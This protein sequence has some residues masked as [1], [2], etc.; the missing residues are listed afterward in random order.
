VTRD[1]DRLSGHADSVPVSFGQRRL[2]FLDR[3]APGASAYLI[4]EYAWLS[5]ELDV[6]AFRAALA[7]LVRR[8][9]TL[10]TVY[11]TTDGEPV[12]V[13]LSPDDDDV[14]DLLT[15]ADSI[16]AWA[17]RPFDLSR[18]R[19]LRAGLVP[20][21]GGWLCGIVVHHIAA[22]GW[23]MG[24]L[25][26]ELALFY[27][28][29]ASRIPPLATDYADYALWQ[30]ESMADGSVADHLDYW[31]DQLDGAPP[32]LELPFDRPRPAMQSFRVTASP[33]NCATT[34]WPGSTTSRRRV[35]RPCSWCC[36]RCIWC[37]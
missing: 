9:A 36:W 5:P 34:C 32:L 26:R 3:L 4:A 15:P 31:L 28:D 27:G 23:S 29:Q 14:L 24:V 19:M 7:A 17:R 2:W 25:L 35:T 1:A 16:A 22:D 8:H 20:A 12:Q 30:R 21:D 11:S 33:S 18:D 37:C 10:R 6:P 13:V